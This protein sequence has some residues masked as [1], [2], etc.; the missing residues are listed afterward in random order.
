MHIDR[1]NEVTM[2]LKSADPACPISAFGLLFMPTARTLTRSS[3]FRASEARDVSSFRFMGEIVDILAI[4]PQGHTLIVVSASIAIAHPMR[5]A[6]EQ[7]SYLM[8]NAKVDDLPA[9]LMTQITDTSLSPMTLFVLGSLQFLPPAGIFLAAGLLPGKLSQLLSPLPFERTDTTACDDQGL[10]CIR[11][12]SRK[13]DLPQVNRRMVL[14]GSRFSLWNFD[15]HMQLKAVV[16]DQCTSSTVVFQLKRQHKRFATLAHWQ[17]HPSFFLAHR[18][19]RPGHRV[20]TFLA[21]RILHLHLRMRFAK[22]AGRCDGGDKHPHDALKR[23]A[24]QRKATLHEVSEVLLTKPFGMG[25]TRLFMRLHAAIPDVR[26]F[27]LSGFQSSK[28]ASRQVAKPIYVW[29][30]WDNCSMDEP[31]VQVGKTR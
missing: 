10:L 1:A 18:L 14:S 29:I 5:I 15:T 16:P 21:P 22:L 28:L 26:R 27:H 6:D 4:F 9:R 19:S 31:M 20:E 3:S 13:V 12:D 25:K 24:M 23:L 11:R 2:A 7:R 30:S 17:D 8:L